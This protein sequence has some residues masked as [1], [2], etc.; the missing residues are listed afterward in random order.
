M[1]AAAKAKAA[2]GE[3]A[4]QPTFRLPLTLGDLT[5]RRVG[6]DDAA[7]LLEY[8][9]DPDVARQQYWEPFTAEGVAMLLL[10]QSHVRP[11]DIGAPLV[12]A[13][14]YGGK[15][16]GDFALT[17]NIPEH[18]QGEV[19]FSFHQGY[20][21]RGL[22]TRALAAVLGFGFVQLGLHRITAATFTS[23][24]RAW[25]LLER[26]GM[27]REAHFIHDGFVRGRWVDVY[28]YGMLA[29]EWRGLHS[30]LV[31]AVSLEQ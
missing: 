20:T 28:G 2:G 25:R 27:R 17:V 12:L 3:M 9:S 18:S 31:A 10:S 29:D 13:A 21:G 24:E 19:G 1:A 7:D 6:G 4:K 11:G 5:M 22:A 23:N 14:E 8:R 26:V 16:V 30:E 15:V